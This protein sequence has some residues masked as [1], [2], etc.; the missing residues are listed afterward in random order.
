MF[1]VGIDGTTWNYVVIQSVSPECDEEAIRLVREGP[2]WR[3]GLLHGQ[4]EMPSQGYV[5][6]EF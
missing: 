3:P 1:N 6:I 4:E 2:K 5:E